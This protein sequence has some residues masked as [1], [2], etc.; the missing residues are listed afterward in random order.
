MKNKI[1]YTK[2]DLI[3]QIHSKIDIPKDHIIPKEKVLQSLHANKSNDY[4]TWIGHATFLIKLGNTTIITDPLFS[5]NA[6]PLF[7]GPII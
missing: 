5:K 1:T 7:L 2:K 6:G 3:D 4:I